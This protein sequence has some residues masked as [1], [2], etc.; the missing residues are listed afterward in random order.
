MVHC[1]DVEPSRS[2]RARRVV[3]G[4]SV[5]ASSRRKFACGAGSAGLSHQVKLPAVKQV[6]ERSYHVSLRFRKQCS[7]R[8]HTSTS[9][10]KKRGAREI[11]AR[12]QTTQ[13]QGGGK[14]TP[15][16]TT[17]RRWTQRP[18]GRGGACLRPGPGPSLQQS[19]AHPQKSKEEFSCK[20]RATR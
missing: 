14:L 1:K 7:T 2:L 6:L 4:V 8:G 11:F 9:T 15:L 13:P 20:R 12:S 16:L 3:G 10:Y 17:L 19:Y 18:V 5:V